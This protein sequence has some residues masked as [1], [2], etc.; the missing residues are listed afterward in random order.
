MVF[1]IFS[2][3]QDFEMFITLSA[4]EKQ[5]DYLWRIIFSGG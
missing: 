1:S 4:D 2:T 3:E 5:N